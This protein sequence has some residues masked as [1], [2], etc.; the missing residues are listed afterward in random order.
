MSWLKGYWELKENISTIEWDVK[1]SNL[2][3][4]R[5]QKE[6]DLF[7]QNNIETSLENQKRL[8]DD[9]KRLEGM[10]E[11]KQKLIEEIVQRIE[12]FEGLENKILKM[13][14]V[15]GI[16]LDII[17]YQLGY[18]SS[19]IYKKHAEII[20]MMKYAAKNSR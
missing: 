5:W 14:Y 3:L 20:R 1:R 6:G 10:L 13:K 15:D 18:S 19:Y 4:V 9:I 7:Q 17:A 11:E 12:S 16:T 8:K 2:E